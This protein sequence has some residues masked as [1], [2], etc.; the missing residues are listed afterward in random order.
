MDVSCASSSKMHLEAELL[1]EPLI[2]S[3][4]VSVLEAHSDLETGLLAFDWVFKV[5]HSVFALETDF[6]DAVTSWHQVIVVHQLQR[7]AHRLEHMKHFAP[8]TQLTLMNGLILQ[9]L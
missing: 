9:F 8:A 1:E 4:L 7:E 3:A 6:W 5:F 2:L